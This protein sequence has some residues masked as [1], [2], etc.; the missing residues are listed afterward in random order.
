MIKGKTIVTFNSV[1]QLC[2]MKFG[3]SSSNPI[4]ITGKLYINGVESQLDLV[5]PSDVDS[6]GNYAFYGCQNLNTIS[7]GSIK[8]IGSYTF[9]GCRGLSS[10]LIPDNVEAINDGAFQNCESL[11]SVVIGEGV[12]SIGSYSFNNCTKLSSINMPS[13]LARIGYQAFM[14]DSMLTSLSLPPSLTEIGDESFLHCKKL[15][16]VNIPNSVTTIGA[17]AFMGCSS[18]TSVIIPNSVKSIEGSAFSGCTS[19]NNVSLPS[20]LEYVGPYAFNETPWYEN[21]CKIQPD[22]LLY[23]GKVCYKYNGTMPENAKLVVKEGTQYLNARLFSDST[24]LVSIELP[25]SLLQI[26]DNAFSGCSGLTSIDIPSSVTSIGQY[27]FKGCS[28]LTSIIIPEGVT[29]IG[30][31]AFEDCSSLSSITFPGSLKTISDNLFGPNGGSAS[32]KSITVGEGV[33]EIYG[34]KGLKNATITLPNSLTKIGSQAFDGCRNC[35]VIIGTGIKDISNSFSG[36]RDMTIYIH[37]FNRPE[38]SYHCFYMT[39]GSCKSFVPFGRGDAYRSGSG[40]EGGYYWCSV[41]EMPYPA[42][43]IGFSGYA[44]YCP[45]KALDF[46]EVEDVKAYIAADY[47]ASLVNQ[48][49]TT[50]PNVRPTS[51]IPTSYA[52]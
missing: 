42:L 20:Q 19:L 25:Q 36:T 44:T 39:N 31:C 26:S 45:N 34:F 13:N 12:R 22:G 32:L 33:E 17:W 14:C 48:V 6:I 3:S 46:S 43:T 35:T 49:H 23:F 38:T 29:S 2:H 47:I 27:A 10:I 41:S 8:S 52:E 5:L 37:A 9:C 15:E 11:T 51:L 24:K 21:Y 7:L 18:L 1:K 28:G 50:S 4:S 30:Y 40:L 16:S